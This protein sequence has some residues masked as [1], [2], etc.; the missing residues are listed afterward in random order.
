MTDLRNEEER[1]QRQEENEVEQ[2]R[3]AA[4][5]LAF[6]RGLSSTE[7]EADVRIFAQKLLELLD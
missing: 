2:K 3:Q 4:Q 1:V 6:E 7:D 5:K